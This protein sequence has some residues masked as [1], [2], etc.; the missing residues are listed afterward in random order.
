LKKLITKKRAGGVAQ[1][2]GPGFKSHTEKE[3]EGKEEKKKWRKG[4]REGGSS[5]GGREGKQV[6]QIV[7]WVR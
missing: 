6:C 1:D 4:G 2:V 7:M 5:E 3:G